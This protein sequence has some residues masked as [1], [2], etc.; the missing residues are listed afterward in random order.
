MSTSDTFSLNTIYL[1]I[2]DYCESK[3]ITEKSFRLGFPPLFYFSFLTDS[4]KLERSTVF[5]PER[6]NPLFRDLVKYLHNKYSF[7]SRLA[8]IVEQYDLLFNPNKKECYRVETYYAIDDNHKLRE[9]YTF[10][11]F[12]LNSYEHHML[13]NEFSDSEPLAFEHQLFEYYLS[14]FTNKSFPEELKKP[15]SQ[16]SKNELDLVRMITI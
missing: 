3:G 7:T 6:V 8:P 15:L 12:E 5:Y 4:V 16:L 9:Q 2:Q 1:N 13:L 14:N 10:I 11:F